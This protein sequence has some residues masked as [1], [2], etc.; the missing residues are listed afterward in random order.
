MIDHKIQRFNRTFN[1]QF[2]KL[3]FPHKLNNVNF[4]MLNSMALEN[5]GCKFCHKTQK[6]LKKI[7][8]TLEC[9]RSKTNDAESPLPKKCQKN[10]E[11]KD[12]IYSQPIIFTHFPLYRESDDICPEVY[13][14][15]SFNEVLQIKVLPNKCVLF[16][17]E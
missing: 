6:Q 9:L 16:S 7:N 3:T 5:D 12:K 17:F 14:I 13:F 4:L 2:A 1:G 15:P 10:D 8:T 11:L